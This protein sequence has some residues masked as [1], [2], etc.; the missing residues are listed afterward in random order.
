MPKIESEK[1][2]I[3]YKYLHRPCSRPALSWPNLTP[4]P[5]LASPCQIRQR[6]F[7]PPLVKLGKPRLPKLA[8]P[9]VKLCI[10]SWNHAWSDLPTDTPAPKG[11]FE[12]YPHLSSSSRDRSFLA[13]LAFA[14]SL[15]SRSPSRSLRDRFPALFA[16]APSLSSR[17]L[18]RFLRDHSLV[19]SVNAPSITLFSFVL[20]TRQLSF[21][22]RSHPS[23][24]PSLPPSLSLSLSLFSLI[25]QLLFLS[26]CV[27]VCV[28]VCVYLTS[29]KQTKK[30]PASDLD[31][32]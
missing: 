30:T 2:L 8:S 20:S 12:D 9:L 26:P 5:D 4:L 14:P 29:V 13:L 19:L 7:W 3:G 24:P 25:K 1:I 28:C 6:G 10:G 23:L 31:M 11:L 15:S 16:I 32:F 22:S 21:P 17:S 18:P 27:C